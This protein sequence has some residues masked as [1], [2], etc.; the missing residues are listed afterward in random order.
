MAQAGAAEVL[1][2]A[3]LTPETLRTEVTALLGD[4]ERLQRMS[5]S[6]KALAR[7][8]AAARI[9][10]EVMRA[11]E[12]LPLETAPSTPPR[13]APYSPPSK[14]STGQPGETAWAGRR[15]HFVG[16]GGAG[17]SGLALIA[18]ELGADVSGC[19]RAA[20]AFFRELKKAGI[21][22]VVGHDASH[23]Q[24]ETE[25][26]VSTAIP[27]DL[28]EVRAAGVVLHRSEL[29]EQATKLKRAIAVGGTHGKTTTTA[30]IA[31]VLRECGLDP[32]WAVGA[33]L[34][35]ANAAWGSG[36]WMVV[37]A[38]ESDRSFLRLDP[39]VAV[40]TNVELDH[41][42]T[43]A[44]EL[45]VRAAF[46]SF[47]GRVRRDGTVVMW[48]GAGLAVPPGV[49]VMRFGLAAGDVS[50]RAVEPTAHG[51]RFEVVREGSTVATVELAAPGEHNV[52]NALAALGA[53][54]AA[55]CELPEAAA[56]LAGF[57]PAGRRFELQGE[58]GGVRVYDDYAH[59][60]TEVEATLRA[61]R[62]LDPQRVV[63]VF[64]PHL[65][66]RTL[67][68]HRELGQA[69]ALA[70]VAVV[71]DV[72][73][74]RERPEGELAGVTGKLVA[75]AAADSAHGRPVW[76]LPTIPEAERVL[77]GIV[78]AGDL[79]LTLGAG[80]VDELARHLVTRLR[81]GT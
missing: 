79:V 14:V 16:I 78:E 72:Y 57:R 31:H 24:P 15:L 49:S 5:S 2:D 34:D 44:S 71:L 53:A 50:A 75:D 65:Y 25:L 20:S 8:D 37:E 55:G 41:H 64:Q 62:T 43:Y 9:A 36:E 67:H 70:D 30:M 56:A 76:W 35:D 46:D 1:P 47:L 26:V 28:A 4:P 19:D 7:P 32:G 69:L 18:K 59:H 73:P 58:V 22:P 27:D 39:A 77:P 12:R 21:E 63:A 29:L 52:L 74:A 33:E 54:E 80:N 48:E 45:E 10:D 40:I 51:T 6:S 61:A 17:M 66:S 42:A 38:D 13:A 23:V 81:D 60:A 68:T 11:M 3:E